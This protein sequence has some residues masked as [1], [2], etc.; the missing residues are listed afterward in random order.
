M[1]RSSTL[2]LLGVIVLLA[3]FIGVPG[4]WVELI[5]TIA[6]IMIVG[7]GI[8][9]RPAASPQEMPLTMSDAPHPSA[10]A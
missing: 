6:G 4:D 10:I 3:P 7:F 8:A 9:L 2:I 5:E 1:S